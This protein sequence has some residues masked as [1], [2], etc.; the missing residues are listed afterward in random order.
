MFTAALYTIAKTWRQPKYALTGEWINKIY[1][2]TMEYYS[3]VQKT[4]MT[5]FAPTWIDLEMIVFTEV[6][7]TKTNKI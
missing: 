6:S 5:P 2:R 4:E 7:Q 3:A 1:I